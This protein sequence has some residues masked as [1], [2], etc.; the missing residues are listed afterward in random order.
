MQYWS[1][2]D[3]RAG[4]GKV[5]RADLDEYPVLC[6][7]DPAEYV[8]IAS[9]LVSEAGYRDEWRAREARFYADEIRGIARYSKRYFDT[10]NAIA[11]QV[12]SP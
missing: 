6:A 5:S 9:R 8:E 3:A 1:E 12:L 10:V 2:V 4:A 11:D 7:R